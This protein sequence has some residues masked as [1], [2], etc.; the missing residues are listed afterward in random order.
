MTPSEIHA[1]DGDALDIRP[2]VRD[3][4]ALGIGIVGSGNIVEHAHIP[5]YRAAGMRVVAV[6]SR[7]LSN[8]E[9]LASRTGIGRAYPGIE[10]LVQD[11]DVAIVDIAVPPDHQ[12]AIAAVAMAAGKHVLAQKPVA[13]TF[14]QARAMVDCA[15]QNRVVLA[16]NQNGRFDPSINAARTLIRQ[17]LLG[18]RIA[19]SMQMHIKMPWQEFYR[20]PK[21]QRLMLLNMSVHHLDQ[22]RWLFG[23]PGLITA[24][25]RHVPNDVFPGENLASYALRYDDGFVVTGVDSGADWSTDFS[26]TYR[27]LGTQAVLIG[28]VGWP[29]NAKSTLRYE[30]KKQP[31][32]WHQLQFTRSWFP[33][34]FSATMGELMSAIEQKRVPTNSGLDTLDTMRA[35]F[36]AYRSAELG[37][38]I[39]LND[40]QS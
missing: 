22:F 3:P 20:D 1:V 39:A 12:P 13:E 9:G 21:Y 24:T 36:A 35:V 27:I 26:I 17:G 31:G 38:T 11:P 10:A 23:T 33:D 16:V 32:A 5:S 37:Q 19:C 28:E 15:A 25:T 30:L 40:I 2:I 8:A 29:R 7:T 34:A 18:E 6:A 4:T 14:A